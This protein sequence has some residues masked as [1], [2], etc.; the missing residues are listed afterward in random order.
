MRATARAAGA[1]RKKGRTDEAETIRGVGGRSPGRSWR[2]SGA[3]PCPRPRRTCSRGRPA[4]QEA[5][6]PGDANGTGAAMIDTKAGAGQVCIGVALPRP[7]SAP[8]AM[9]IHSGAIGRRGADRRRSDAGAH[10]DWLRIG[11]QAAGSRHRRDNPASTTSTSTR[12]PS[13]TGRSAAARAEPGRRAR[14]GGRARTDVQV[15][16]HE[17]RPGDA[18]PGRPERHRGPRSSTCKAGHRPGL[19]RRPLP[20]GSTRPS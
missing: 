1:R 9:H 12:R 15:R 8:T 11:R 6:G 14:V 20:Q 19:R 2:R 16:A 3:R 4:T 10:R 7:R 13:S 18:V 17:R 5:P